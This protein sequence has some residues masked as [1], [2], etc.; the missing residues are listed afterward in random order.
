MDRAQV[1]AIKKFEERVGKADGVG[2][3]RRSSDVDPYE[4]IAT[5]SLTLHDR[6]TVGG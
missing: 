6:L 3:L 5:G 2:T 1:A 4:V